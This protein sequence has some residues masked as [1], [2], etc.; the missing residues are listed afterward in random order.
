MMDVDMKVAE[1][2][3]KTTKEKI[4]EWQGPVK[5]PWASY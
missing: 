5:K 4:M 2:C 1:R 3:L